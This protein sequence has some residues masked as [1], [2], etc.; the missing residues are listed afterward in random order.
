MFFSKSFGYALRGILYVAMMSDEKR[1]IRIDEMASRLAVPRHFLGKIMNKVVKKHILSSTKGPNGGFFLNNS[2]LTTP[3]LSV[4]EAMDGLDQFDT[5]VLRLK[6]CNEESPCPLH[7]LLQPE[8]K[9]LLQVFAN[10]N[11]GDL[12]K[13]D[14]PEF[15]RSISAME[16]K[17]A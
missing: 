17:I 7:F 3:L 14:K 15:I 10:T 4:L 8:R 6:T 16:M 5:C 12:L 11:V 13:E 9:R 1:K 2:T